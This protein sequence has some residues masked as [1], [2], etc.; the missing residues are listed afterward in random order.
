M[1]FRH[2]KEAVEL[3]GSRGRV[4]HIAHSQGA[5]ITYLASKRLTKAEMSQ[6]EVICFIGPS[7]NK[8]SKNATLKLETQE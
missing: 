6:I 1:K 3:V 7:K 2:L 5:L 4:I 8:C